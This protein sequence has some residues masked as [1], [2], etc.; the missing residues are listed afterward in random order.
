MTFSTGTG[1]QIRP[2]SSL[3]PRTPNIRDLKKWR[4]WKD[5]SEVKSSGYSST[6]PTFGFQHLQ[7]SLQHPLLASVSTS[8]AS[9][10]KTYIQAK[11]PVH[12]KER[13]QKETGM[14]FQLVDCLPRM[15]EVL[16]PSLVA[17][18]QIGDTPSNLTNWEVDSRSEIQGHHWLNSKYE[19]SLDHMKLCLKNREETEKESEEQGVGRDRGR[20]RRGAADTQS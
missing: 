14:Q 15:Q 19:G 9:S 3:D 10:T 6:G 16:V 5:D 18:N 13:T 17:H 11:H 4:T 20:E 12:K 7:G 1:V 2:H 8:F